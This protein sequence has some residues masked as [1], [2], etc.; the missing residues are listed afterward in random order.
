MFLNEHNDYN[1]KTNFVS[2]F[3]SIRFEFVYVRIQI[4]KTKFDSVR[5]CITHFCYSFFSRFCTAVL[6]S[7]IA[8]VFFV[9]VIHLSQFSFLFGIT[10]LVTV[11]FVFVIHL[12]QL[13][14]SVWYYKNCYS[15]FVSIIHL[16]QF[17]V[18]VRYYQKKK[19]V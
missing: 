10:K 13:F 8:T 9:S 6:H 4:L 3:V 12:L 16:L 14:V 19:I 2:N 7:N 5:F 17:F 15:F 18:S 1:L 11:F